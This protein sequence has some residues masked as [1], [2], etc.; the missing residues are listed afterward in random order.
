MPTIEK[1]GLR[2]Y[3]EDGKPDILFPSCTTIIGWK[4]KLFGKWKGRKAGDMANCGTGIHFQIEKYIFDEYGIGDVENIKFP[5]IE[6]WNMTEEQRRYKEN[7]SMKMWFRFLRDHITFKPVAQELRLFQRGKYRY[8]GRLDQYDFIEGLKVLLDVKTGG[9]W[10]EYDYQIAGYYQ[11]LTNLDIE[12]DECWLLFLDAN[13]ERNP[14]G[15]YQIRKYEKD[16]IEQNVKVFNGLLEE[17]YKN[18]EMIIQVCMEEQFY[19]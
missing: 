19:E 6:I 3:Y 9:Y 1:Q 2:W 12:V 5:I 16:E 7:E 17:Y 4:D 11:L 10:P 13:I 15:N 18:V 8:A 14:S